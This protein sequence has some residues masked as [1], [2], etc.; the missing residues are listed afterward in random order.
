MNQSVNGSFSVQHSVESPT[1]RLLIGEFDEDNQD[2]DD[3][4]LLNPDDDLLLSAETLK[5]M[6]SKKHSDH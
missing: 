1:K 4:L 6:D 2:E 5:H 3:D